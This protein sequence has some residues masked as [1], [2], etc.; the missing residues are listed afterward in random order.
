MVCIVLAP[1]VIVGTALRLLFLACIA[2]SAIGLYN[3][4]V[5]DRLRTRGAWSGVDV[6][7]KRRS[8]LIPNLVETVQ[9]Y[10][11]DDSP[12]T[13]SPGGSSSS[14]LFFSPPKKVR[15]RK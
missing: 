13:S 4:L 2:G 9:G 5:R 15:R 11:G 12:A 1:P 3:R 14:R 7:L 6:Q 10:A 8:S